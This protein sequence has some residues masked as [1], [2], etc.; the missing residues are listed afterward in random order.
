MHGLDHFS[1][2]EEMSH[3]SADDN[4]G[5]IPVR[6]DLVLGAYVYKSRSASQDKCKAH[7]GLRYEPHEEPGSFVANAQAETYSA[8]G[9]AGNDEEASYNARS[10]FTT[11]QVPQSWKTSLVTPVFKHG[12]A[13]DTANYRPISVGEPISRLYANIMVQRL[14]TYTE[15]QQ[16]RSATQTGYRPELGTIH[17]AFALQH[18]VDKHRHANKPLYLCFVDLKSAYDKVQ[19]QLLWSLLQRL[20]VHGHMLGAVQSLYHG[21]LL[22][23]RVNGQCGHSQSPSIDSD[24]AAHSVPPCL[25]SSLMGCITICRPQLQLLG[26]KSGT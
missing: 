21:S 14:V 7:K 13:T 9:V 17:P 11:G 19:W 4:P 15:Q 26:F 2:I 24:R 23:M 25:A 18:A 16:L 10:A 22:S 12:D 8:G 3:D 6:C 5:D 20:G 1:K